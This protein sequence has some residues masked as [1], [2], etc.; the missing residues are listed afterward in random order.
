MLTLDDR[1]I[2][3]ELLDEFE[4]DP[5][6]VPGDIGSSVE[7]GVATL[8]GTVH[9]FMEKWAAEDAAKR[10]R[11]IRAIA[12]DL[13]VE[14]PGTHKPDDTDLAQTIASI[15]SW[16]AGLPKTIVAEVEGGSV[17]LTGTVTHDYQR[18]EIEAAV[19]RL[20]G[21]RSVA[22][23]IALGTSVPVSEIKRK[24]ESRF[25]RGASFDAHHVLV[26]VD[27]GTV[28]LS[29]KV[30]SLAEREAAVLAAWSVAGVRNV[31]DKIGVE[32]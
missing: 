4:L 8:T 17:T 10:V 12:N 25:A 3:E 28:T 7:R 13:A 30:R 14:L 22:N 20:T 31:V 1:A 9:S 32:L 24:V 29:G 23:R 16:D 19:R 6:I 21:V 2:H 26:D 11:G 5:R 15:V 27:D 18:R